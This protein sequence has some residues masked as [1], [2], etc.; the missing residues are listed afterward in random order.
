MAIGDGVNDIDM[1]SHVGVGVAM[2]NGSEEAK[3][4]SDMVTSPIGQDGVFNALSRL[5][6]ILD[7]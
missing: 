2:G 6:L 7:K 3:A 5:G 4:A 1:L